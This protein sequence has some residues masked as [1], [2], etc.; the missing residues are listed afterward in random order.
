[1]LKIAGLSTTKLSCVR[2]VKSTAETLGLVS[3]QTHTNLIRTP[4]HNWLQAGTRSGALG[5]SPGTN[6]M[7]SGQERGHQ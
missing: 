4:G 3:A 5:T 2:L 1:M 6:P 7:G